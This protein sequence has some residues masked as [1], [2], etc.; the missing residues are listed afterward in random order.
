VTIDNRDTRKK[1]LI[2]RHIAKMTPEEIARR[3][4]VHIVPV[5]RP[6]KAQSGN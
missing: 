2:G 6:L 4:S 3:F 1:L 5:K